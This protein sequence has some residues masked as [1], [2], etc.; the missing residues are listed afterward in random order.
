MEKSRKYCCFNC[1]RSVVGISHVFNS[2]HRYPDCTDSIF[3]VDPD[4]NLH[5]KSS[6]DLVETNP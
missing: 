5:E 2:A 3:I 1:W 6:V 4:E